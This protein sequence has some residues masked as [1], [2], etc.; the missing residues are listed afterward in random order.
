MKL[1]KKAEVK[2]NKKKAKLVMMCISIAAVMSVAQNIN[3]YQMEHNLFNE[4]FIL[5][6]TEEQVQIAPKD[7]QEMTM[8]DL[9]NYTLLSGKKCKP[10]NIK[11]REVTKNVNDREFKKLKLKCTP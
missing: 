4:D 9:E 7:S 8:D 10:E 3:D 11:L 6:S 2:N 5:L 1:F